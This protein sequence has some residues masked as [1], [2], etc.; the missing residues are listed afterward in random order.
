MVITVNTQHRCAGGLGLLRMHV[1]TRIIWPPGALIPGGILCWQSE[2]SST[3]DDVPM[4]NV[5]LLCFLH[6]P[7]VSR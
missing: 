5:S 7:E 3:K 6:R 4:P 1:G 2:R